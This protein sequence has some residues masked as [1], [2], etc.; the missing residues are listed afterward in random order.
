MARDSEPLLRPPRGLALDLSLLQPRQLSA[1][2]KVHVFWYGFDC[3]LP[4]SS[5][6]RDRARIVRNHLGAGEKLLE[7][8]VRR[9]RRSTA[10]WWGGGL[11][12][13]RKSS[14]K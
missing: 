14:G 12:L 10:T 8:R 6:H 7:K 1:T 11:T 5:H 3:A 4:H 2:R 13:Q 9:R